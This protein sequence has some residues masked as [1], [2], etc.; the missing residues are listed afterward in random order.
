[1]K[2]ETKK[3]KT[4]SHEND[5]KERRTVD[6]NQFAYTTRELATLL[7]LNRNTVRTYIITGRIRSFKIGRF[8]MVPREELDRIKKDYCFVPEQKAEA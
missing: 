7:G 2:D 8:H 3:Q 5:R 4:K 1:M 6:E